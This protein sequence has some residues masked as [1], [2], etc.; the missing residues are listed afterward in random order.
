[1]KRD[2]NFGEKRK[3][4]R[5]ANFG[6][7]HSFNA[8][9]RVLE[10]IC[11]TY[12]N[13]RY[14]NHDEHRSGIDILVIPDG[15]GVNPLLRGYSE[16]VI[17]SVPCD[18]KVMRFYETAFKFYHEQLSLPILGIGDGASLLWSHLGG[19]LGISKNKTIMI[20]GLGAQLVEVDD[21]G[22]VT[23]FK[24]GNLAGL[25]EQSHMMLGSILKNVAMQVTK[26]NED[27]LEDDFGL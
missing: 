21:L 4:K 2:G 10:S 13:V 17:P 7:L 16:N 18:P 15:V 26:T 22:I 20:G 11:S 25:S 12:G 19:K 6:I 14:I 9:T 5:R 23:R 27:S 3:L 24:Q 8:D 1:M